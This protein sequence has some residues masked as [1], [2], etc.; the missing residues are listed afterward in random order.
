MADPHWTSYVGMA[1]GLIG[2]CTGI[3]GYRK[4]SSLKS[5]DLR[6]EL[7]KSTHNAHT[8]LSQLEDLINKANRSR[9]AVASA[10]GFLGSGRM[11]KWKADIETDK[12]KLES[13]LSTAPDPKD[14]PENYSQGKLELKL[15]KIHKF[16]MEIDDLKNKYV[17]ELLKDDEERKQ[18]REDNRASLTQRQST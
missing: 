2:A 1:T 9:D 18:I 5:L 13:L 16:Q 8:D 15:I 14:N 12:A 6:L 17:D 3:I 10:R 11:I 4:A 7:R